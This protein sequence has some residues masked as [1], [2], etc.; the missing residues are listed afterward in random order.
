MGDPMFLRVGVSEPGGTFYTQ[1]LA[2]RDVFKDLPGLPS[3]EVVESRAGASIENAL[4]LE[5]GDLDMAFISAPWVAAAI[6]GVSPFARRLDLRTVAPMNLGP[7]FF[8]ARADS[9]LHHVRDLKGRR[10]AIGL[11]SSGMT[12][13]AEAVLG[14]IGIG[15]DDIEKVYV[16]FAE[17]AR[18]LVTGAVDA[19]YQRPIPNR[20]MTHLCQQ[21]DV[22][23]LR[24]D[25]QEIEAALRAVPCD[26][27]ISMKAGSVPNL[28]DDIPQLGVLNLLV[29]HRRC[30]EDLVSRVTG[31]IIEHAPRLATLLPLFED[32]PALLESTRGDRC[33]S[34][35]FD[36]VALH[37]GAARA[38][39]DAG[40][41]T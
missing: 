30:E 31:A 38:Y 4:R 13:H 32:L 8:V 33:A 15:P 5:S 3:I 21:V 35:E 18:L 34:L 14:A 25:Q 7:N 9:N 28:V 12:P 16:D 36:G 22:R 20:V 6:K 2:L 1:A 39:A 10:L 11:P 29:T 27:P 19:Q 26:R 24:F 37:P 41:M 17:G 40:Y 23:I